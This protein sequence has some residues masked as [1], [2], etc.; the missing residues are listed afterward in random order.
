MYPVE[1]VVLLFAL[2]EREAARF[3]P[4]GEKARSICT[5]ESKRNNSRHTK[6]GHGRLTGWAWPCL[7]Q[8][9]E[10]THREPA[11]STASTM[12]STSRRIWGWARTRTRTRRQQPRLAAVEAAELWCLPKRARRANSSGT[13]CLA[14]RLPPHRGM[15][16]AVNHTHTHTRARRQTDRQTDRHTLTHRHT[17]TQTHTHKGTRIDNGAER[18][19]EKRDACVLVFAR[20]ESAR[21]TLACCHCC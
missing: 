6:A 17:D 21:V 8:N 3:G 14:L 2:I 4:R 20:V 19:K 12:T 1:G 15:Q 10:T 13:P 9:H 18:K 7:N 5:A 16:R 11:T